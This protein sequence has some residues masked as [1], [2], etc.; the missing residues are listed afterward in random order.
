MHL[1]Q[2]QEK[3]IHI[4]GDN[5][6]FVNSFD[7]NGERD[8]KTMDVRINEEYR[9]FISGICKKLALRRYATGDIICHRGDPGEEM[10][11]IQEGKVGVFIEYKTKDVEDQASQLH[12]LQELFIQNSSEPFTDAMV[13]KNVD[14]E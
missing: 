3:I 6:F 1:N 13:L 8:P 9:E 11:V 4:I 2:D 5:N 7:S 14:F 10:F 12:R